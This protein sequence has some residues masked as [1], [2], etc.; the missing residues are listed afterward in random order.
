MMAIFQTEAE[1]ARLV[2]IIFPMGG[3]G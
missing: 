3:P 1:F 2:L